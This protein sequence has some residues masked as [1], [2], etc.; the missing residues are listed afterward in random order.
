MK[1]HLI[2][3]KHFNKYVNKCGIHFE[4]FLMRDHSGGN[5]FAIATQNSQFLHTNFILAWNEVGTLVHAIRM[6]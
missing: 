3:T 6:H 2:F 1:S 5:Q 4:F